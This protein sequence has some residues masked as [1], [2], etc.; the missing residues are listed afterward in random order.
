MSAVV[1]AIMEHNIPMIPTEENSKDRVLTTCETW[2]DAGSGIRETFARLTADC[3]VRTS[4]RVL[5]VKVGPHLEG[6]HQLKGRGRL[7]PGLCGPGS[8]R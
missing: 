2:K 4:T 3:D 8:G 5:D 1:A 6:S 7:T